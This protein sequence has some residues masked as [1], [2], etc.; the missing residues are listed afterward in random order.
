[1]SQWFYFKDGNKQGPISGAQLREM[2]QGGKIQPTDQLWRE[3]LQKWVSASKVKGLFAN[4]VPQNPIPTAP[5]AA[6][7][8]SSSDFDWLNTTDQPSTEPPTTPPT[9]PPPPPD[10]F[11]RAK[12]Y[13]ENSWNTASIRKK[14]VILGALFILA[15]GGIRGCDGG[16]AA[17]QKQ[18][19]ALDQG[20]DRLLYASSFAGEYESNEVAAD[21][22]YKGETVFV[23]GEVAKVRNDGWSSSTIIV[24]AANYSAFNIDCVLSSQSARDELL[25]KVQAGRWIRVS[26]TCKGKVMG[27]VTL[28]NCHFLIGLDD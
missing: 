15:I 25:T 23:T 27:T 14:T 6:E 28:K 18:L 22:K 26:G 8:T 19:A 12:T 3:G 9:I 4:K 13:I 1:M 2:V 24:L 11:Q 5:P 16:M 21:R 17:A 20:D 7:I 10:Y